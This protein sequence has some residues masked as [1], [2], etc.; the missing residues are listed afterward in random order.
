MAKAQ[1]ILFTALV[2]AIIS[3][4]TTAAHD[5]TLSNVTVNFIAL[6]RDGEF[7]IK[8][9]PR[10]R[11]DAL[12]RAWPSVCNREGRVAIDRAVKQKLIAPIQGPAF[13]MA[14]TFPPD[15][16][17]DPHVSSITLSRSFPLISAKAGN[18]I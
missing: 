4:V 17:S 15:Y 13:G 12:N 1:A 5:A 16:S 9:S 10:T 2:A 7:T 8:C 18:P 14:S 3:P 6:K 11:A